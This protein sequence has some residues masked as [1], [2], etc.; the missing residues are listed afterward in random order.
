MKPLLPIATEEILVDKVYHMTKTL[1]ILLTISFGQLFSQKADTLKFDRIF[2]CSCC[3][4]TIKNLVNK[5]WVY[6]LTDNKSNLTAYKSG[7]VKWTKSTNHIWGDNNATFDCV[8]FYEVNKKVVLR[9]Y[10]NEL[11]SYGEF[12]PKTGEYFGRHQT[13]N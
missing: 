9:V 8:E 4:D 10:C 1:L 12:D 7:K 6:I 3:S 5:H 2:G 13:T 11:K